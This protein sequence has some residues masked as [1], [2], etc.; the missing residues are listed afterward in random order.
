MRRSLHSFFDELQKI[1][2]TGALLKSPIAKQ[3]VTEHQ[4]LRATKGIVIPPRKAS[5]LLSASRASRPAPPAPKK[6]LSPEASMLAKLQANMRKPSGAKAAGDAE[7]A[8]VAGRGY[9]RA[10]TTVE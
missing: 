10:I 2:F 7:R 8:A 6:A 1:A 4:K 3:L 9:G 5:S